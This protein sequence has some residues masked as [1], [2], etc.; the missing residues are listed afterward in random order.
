MKVFVSSGCGQG[1]G[2][3]KRAAGALGAVCGETARSGQRSTGALHHRDGDGRAGG[4]VVDRAGE[5]MG[6][7]G[8]KTL[9]VG[10]SVPGLI[11]HR[12]GLGLLSPNLHVQHIAFFSLT[13]NQERRAICMSLR[14]LR[15]KALIA[16]ATPRNPH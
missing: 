8:M 13:P 1:P 10:I 6:P 16:Q 15:P 14:D 3:V 7:P 9:G 11:D 5:L 4:G 2:T 12:R